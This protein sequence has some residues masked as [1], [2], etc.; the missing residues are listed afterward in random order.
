MEIEE[1]R[2]LTERAQHGDEQALEAIKEI[3]D[4]WVEP[5][6]KKVGESALKAESVILDHI[7]QRNLLYTNNSLHNYPGFP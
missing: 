7:C 2:Q 4:P 5:W 6:L 1:I 3:S